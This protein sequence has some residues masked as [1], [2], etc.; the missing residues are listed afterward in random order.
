[1]LHDITH[2]YLL[3]HTKMTPGVVPL[4]TSR[5]TSYLCKPSTM[6]SYVN[7]GEDTDGSLYSL[8]KMWATVKELDPSK[9]MWT[10]VTEMQEPSTEKDYLEATGKLMLYLVRIA[11][12]S[13]DGKVSSASCV[14]PFSDVAASVLSSR[15][16]NM[17]GRRRCLKPVCPTVMTMI[18]GPR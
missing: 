11:W 13:G 18:P 12:R 15:R 2:E 16:G 8:V 1:M 4:A 9:R 17:L 3:L 5:Q 7:K 10:R 6:H 14:V